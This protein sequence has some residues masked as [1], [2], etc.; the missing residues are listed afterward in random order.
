[1]L[2][3]EKV[4]RKKVPEPYYLVRPYLSEQIKLVMTMSM[5]EGVDHEYT[6]KT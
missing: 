2:L 5:N 6:L 3:T 4:I 1:M